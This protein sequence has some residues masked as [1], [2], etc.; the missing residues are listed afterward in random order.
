MVD[1]YIFNKLKNV[2]E[3]FNNYKM[4]S[5]IRTSIKYGIPMAGTSGTQTENPIQYVYAHK[6]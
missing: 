5:Y 4:F 6:Q 3:L 1:L 2:F